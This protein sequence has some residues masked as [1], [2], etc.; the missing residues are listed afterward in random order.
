MLWLACVECTSSAI[1]FKIGL[2][3]YEMEDVLS[4]LRW[5]KHCSE[6]VNSFSGHK[7]ETVPLCAGKKTSLKG[8]Y[9]VIAH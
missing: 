3:T 4:L 8:D 1:A 6:P 2:N 9:S 5:D 7:L